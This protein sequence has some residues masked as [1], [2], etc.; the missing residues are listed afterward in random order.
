M[1]YIFLHGLGQT[2]KSWE[3]VTSRLPAETERPDLFGML[4]QGGVSY[5][6][7]YGAFSR[8]C[9]SSPEPIAL[10]GLSLG[11]ILAMDYA[12]ENPDRVKSLVLI[13]VQYVMPKLLLKVQNAMFSLM[14]ERMFGDMGMGKRD[15]IALTRSMAE[16]DFSGEI[17]KIACPTLII[18]GERDS[19]NKKACCELGE[20]LPSS[21]LCEIKGAGHEVNRDAPESLAQALREFWNIDG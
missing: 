1:R 3:D 9:G 6:A 14:P 5:K 16:L 10:C 13:G 11:G 18:Y 7:M 4:P 12:I 8:Y 21:R 2:P 15:V 19:A 20:K 17:C